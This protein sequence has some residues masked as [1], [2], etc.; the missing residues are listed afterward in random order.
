MTGDERAHRRVSRMSYKQREEMMRAL[1][2][3][4][5]A[6]S[7]HANST[8]SGRRLRTRFDF[9]QHVPGMAQIGDQISL[10]ELDLLFES[11]TWRE[12]WRPGQEFH[13]YG[14]GC[15]GL[16]RCA[17]ATGTAISKIGT[18][19]V[20]G[21]DRRMQELRRQAYGG[22]T[23]G[24]S[25]YRTESGWNDWAPFHK[26]QLGPTPAASPVRASGH[27][28][29]LTA[30]LG[31]TPGEVE[32]TVNKALAPYRLQHFADSD[33]GRAIC[34]YRGVDPG[35]LIRFSQV[36]GRFVS[37]TELT[38]IR[39]QADAPR[40][41]GIVALA[42]ARTVRSDAVDPDAPGWRLL[43]QDR[44]AEQGF[45]LHDRRSY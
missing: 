10:M 34:K 6:S 33:A 22:A 24:V 8:P 31:W 45:D 9:G 5:V 1:K 21:F 18:A 17:F 37:S 19:V 3:T 14:I 39:P 28:L 23:R 44:C 15:S 26:L 40:L 41:A 25:G 4:P 29:I 38:L 32:A 13:L 2:A 42:I 30:P 7:R 11:A 36:A 43:D 16:G 20:G 35:S 12:A 27:S